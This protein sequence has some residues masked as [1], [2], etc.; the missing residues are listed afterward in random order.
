MSTF[1]QSSVDPA[2]VVKVVQP[3][4]VKFFDPSKYEL[5]DIASKGNLVLVAKIPN[6]HPGKG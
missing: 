3:I 2:K 6:S 4:N 1:V 5:L